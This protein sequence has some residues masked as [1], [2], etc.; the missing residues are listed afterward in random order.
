[1][2]SPSTDLD[3]LAARAAA[4]DAAALDA[5]LTAIRPDV[6]RRCTRILPFSSDAEDAAQE[7]LIAVAKGIH[8]FGGRSRFT[9]WL[10]P[11]VANS[12]FATYRRMR[13]TADEAGLDQAPEVADP[14]R[15]SVLAG[16]RLDLVEALEKLR[17]DQPHVVEAVVLR[18]LMGLDY[19]EIAERLDVPLG[20]VKSRINHART[21]LRVLLAVR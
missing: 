2:T 10:Y 17:V 1:M 16:T 3:A 7:A 11:V 12:A 19:A 8:G 13:R 18:D 14:A 21:S 9:T 20:T 5:L 15:V 6:L 4:G